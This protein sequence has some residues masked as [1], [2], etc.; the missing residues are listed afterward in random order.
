MGLTQNRER[1]TTPSDHQP[2]LFRIGIAGR[3]VQVKRVDLF[4]Q[5]ARY[6]R[7]N[8]PD[9]PSSFHIFG[10]GPMRDQ[11]EAL[12][13]SLDTADIVHFEGHCD[14]I[15]QKLKSLD[16]LLMTSDHEGLPMILLEAM[17]IRL[18]IIAHAVGGIPKLLENGSS[19]ILVQGH[20]A[21][22]Y[23][24]AI[25]RLARSP[26][27][28]INITSHAFNRVATNYSADLN[29][30]KYLAEYLSLSRQRQ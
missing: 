29:A 17:A 22:D 4:L 16:A 10:D 1:L 20:Q 13:N 7:E 19:G 15:H 5:I 12:N 9:L 18:P 28:R 24:D 21:S 26:Q 30:R 25:Y 27:T 14:D 23:A 2:D 8:H 6:I 3:L 11:L